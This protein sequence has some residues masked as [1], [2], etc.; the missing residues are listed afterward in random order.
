M[1]CDAMRCDGGA[2]GGEVGGG[3]D[4]SMDCGVIDDLDCLLTG[5]K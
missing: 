3:K 4:R 1:R 5:Q 2:R